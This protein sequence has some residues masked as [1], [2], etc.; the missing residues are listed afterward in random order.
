MKPIWLLG[1]LIVLLSPIN[2][3]AVM[4]GDGDSAVKIPTKELV[5]AINNHDLEWNTNGIVGMMPERIGGAT[6]LVINYCGPEVSDQLL[7]ALDDPER[8][9]AAHVILGRKNLKEI[10]MDFNMYDQL[11]ATFTQQRNITFDATQRTALKKLWID[12]L[13]Q[14]GAPASREPKGKLPGP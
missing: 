9:V 3:G 5:G 7:A 1:L 6:R 12:R 13:K 2:R 8:F 14:K 4:G 11:V 10:K